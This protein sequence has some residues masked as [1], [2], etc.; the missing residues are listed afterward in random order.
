[1]S[2]F[3]VK[4]SFLVTLTILIRENTVLNAAEITNKQGKSACFRSSWWEILQISKCPSPTAYPSR[5]AAL[6]AEMPRPPPDQP[7][8]VAPL[9]APAKPL[10]L[11]LWFC[12]KSCH[13]WD[14]SL[15]WWAIIAEWSNS[16]S[17]FCISINHVQSLLWTLL[18]E[19]TVE[20]QLRSGSF[21]M[22]V[23]QANVS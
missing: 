21:P 15:P 12:S 2:V 4:F 5:G 11:W 1:M 20:F 17:E 13:C 18:I 14:C 6:Q 23:F 7:P 3:C 19:M 22:E 10:Y 16:L 9:S 8:P